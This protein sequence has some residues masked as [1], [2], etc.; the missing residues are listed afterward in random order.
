MD[1]D[2]FREMREIGRVMLGGYAAS[3]QINR[4]Q[5]DCQCCHNIARHTLT[6]A[7]AMGG[8][9]ERHLCDDHFAVFGRAYPKMM[10][11]PPEFPR[12]PVE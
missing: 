8:M 3:S 6:C 10:Q 7:A 9:L 5:C 4:T 11:S 2:T 12:P 1:D